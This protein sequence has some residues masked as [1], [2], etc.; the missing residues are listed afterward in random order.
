[1]EWWKQSFGKSISGKAF[2]LRFPAKEL[3]LGGQFFFFIVLAVS[4]TI[5]KKQQQQKNT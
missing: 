3:V 4:L 5:P 1:M 2:T